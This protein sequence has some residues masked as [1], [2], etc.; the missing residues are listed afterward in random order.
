[1]GRLKQADSRQ[2][3]LHNIN[4]VLAV[5]GHPNNFS[6][7]AVSFFETDESILFFAFHV[8]WLLVITHTWGIGIVDYIN[9]QPGRQ[10]SR[11]GSFLKCF[12][13]LNLKNAGIV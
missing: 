10:A 7:K 9:G 12:F 11:R 13:M 5:F 4:A 6:Q 3:L 1:M 8:D 2:V